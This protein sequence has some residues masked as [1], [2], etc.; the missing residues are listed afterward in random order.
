MK[1]VSINLFYL[2]IN[3]KYIS[4]NYSKLYHKYRNLNDYIYINNTSLN[5]HIN[6]CKGDSQFSLDLILIQYLFIESKTALRINLNIFL[7]KEGE[8]YYRVKLIHSKLYQ[9]KIP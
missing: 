1:G 4:H 3:K 6:S 8:I 7:Q 9:V 5:G 2:K